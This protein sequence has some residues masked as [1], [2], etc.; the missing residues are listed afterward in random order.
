[1]A[2]VNRCLS[3]RVKK[4]SSLREGAAYKGKPI[5][6]ITSDFWYV[7]T[8]PLFLS[9]FLYSRRQFAHRIADR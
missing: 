2:P 4:E 3:M 8:G 6:G 7:W 9:V 5:I 1:M